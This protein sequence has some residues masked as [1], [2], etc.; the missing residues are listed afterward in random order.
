MKDNK[1]LNENRELPEV[2]ILRVQ[3]GD[4]LVVKI[5]NALTDAQ[6]EEIKKQF[7][8][9]YTGM[10]TKVPIVFLENGAELGVVRKNE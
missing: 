6:I 8:D 7:Q 9:L 4:T 5:K 10:R 3:D 1:K 2:N